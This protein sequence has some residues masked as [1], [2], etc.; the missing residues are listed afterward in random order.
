L[1]R[2]VDRRLLLRLCVPIALALSYAVAVA[3]AAGNAPGK[4]FVV[5]LGRRVVQVEPGG[6]AARAGVQPGDV[7]VAVDGAPVRSTL[8]Y[9]ARA[10][11]VEPGHRLGLT[12]ER[13]GQ[14]RR[15][16]TLLVEDPGTPIAAIVAAVLGLVVMGLGAAARVARPGDPAAR[17]FFRTAC[18][19]SV[20]YAG[21]M[22]WTHVVVHPVL[23]AIFLASLFIAPPLA[24]HLALT[25]P[26]GGP[27]SRRAKLATYAPSVALLIA[28]YAGI[29]VS[30]FTGTDDAM[31]IT[32][33]AIAILLALTVVSGIVGHVLQNRVVRAAGGAARAQLRWITLGIALSVLPGLGALPYAIA[34]FDRFL[35]VGYRP[36]TIA[37]GL[38]WFVFYSLAILRVGLADVDRTIV[39][40]VGY[41]SATTAAAAVYIVVVLAVGLAVEQVAGAELV[42]HVAAGLA[43]AMVF[44]PLRTRVSG[45]LDRR[46]QRDRDHYARALRELADA[47]QRVREPAELTAE[48]T[49]RVVAAVRAESATL[50]LRD[51]DGWVRAAMQRAPDHDLES[52][53]RL[54]VPP[55]APDGGLA[56]PFGAGDTPRGW[57]VLGRRA[58][59]D[60][61][62]HEDQDLLA[63]LAGQLTI[64]LDNAAAYGT[65]ARLSRSLEARTREVEQLRDKLEDEN[66]VL[67]ARVSQIAEGAS[68]VGT[69]KPVIELLAQIERA[70]AASAAILITGE[71]GTGKGLVAKAVHDASPRASK[72]FMHVDCGAIAAGVFES[73]L[74]GHERGA[75]TG[76]IR[77]RHGLFE[78]ADGGTVFLDEIGELPL[79]LQPKLLRAVETGEFHRVGA[80]APTRVDIRIVAATHRD[81]PAMVAAGQFREDL[82]FRLRVIELVVPPLRTRR[83]DLSAL[84]DALLARIA[85]R[86]HR[87]TLPI[88]PE[89]LARIVAYGWPGNVRELEHVLERASVL[90][91]GEV[92][93]VEDLGIADLP[94]LP[95]EPATTAGIDGAHGD[96]MD[97]IER[98]RLVAA[99][100]AAGGNRSQA[101]RALGL[102]RTTFLNKLRR[103][104]LVD[105]DA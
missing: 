80:Q 60:L 24:L 97:E 35:V 82:Y 66:R 26:A 52:P 56:L 16:V 18:G 63:A 55:R 43:A 73:E 70:A 71:T 105:P 61:Y 28:C 22:S 11:T 59:G 74:F 21:V 103:H 78:L 9:A 72:P 10:L 86:T 15:D 34:D 64:A 2:R 68:L 101:A 92:I 32:V 1:L 91:E 83:S 48:V 42:S 20:F 89:A 81:L 6:P 51:R 104:G 23:G 46:F 41:A 95:D 33:A 53:E 99:L 19:V 98:R 8:A 84:C 93:R 79:A 87:D 25:F 13:P 85:K 29:V 5:F 44:G 38:L 3:V 102:P 31:P 69:S 57:L 94:V 27:L 47:V 62:S 58:S 96:V 4:G 17:R 100:R 39:R 14:G 45:W 37:V 36:F 90:A 54:A 67:R 7:V 76:A 88:S 65:I 30:R 50:Y 75:F 49:G 77:Q 12:L 40:S